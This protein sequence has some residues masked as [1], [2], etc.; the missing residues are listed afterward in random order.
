MEFLTQAL[1]A[2]GTVV[3][4]IAF[5]AT[6]GH[7]VLLANG[8]RSL[9]GAFAAPGV[10][11]PAWAGV[12][13]GSFV[14]S[15]AAVAAAGPADF[16]A[17]EPAL[18]RLALA[19]DRRV[20]RVRRLDGRPGRHR[21]SRAVG[22]PVRVLGRVRDVDP[23]RLPRALAPLPDRLDRV[24]PG[25]RRA[26]A[27]AVRVVAPARGQ[28]ARA[29]APEPAAAHDPRRAGGARRTASSRRRSR[30]GSATSSR[31]ARTGTPGC[32]RTASS[33]PSPIAR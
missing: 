29:R 5:A 32:R 14:D 24:H 4:A 6:V 19:D 22:Q 21:R 7:A 2:A 3:L 20:P 12:A 9:A 16:A 33:M 17:P 8:R 15:R 27:R 1:F 31:A 28:P 25:R 10:I 18:A 13:T 11:R 30:R 23:V 26:R